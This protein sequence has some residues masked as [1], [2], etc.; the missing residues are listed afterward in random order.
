MAEIEVGH[1]YQEGKTLCKMVF[2]ASRKKGMD[3]TR[4]V[5]IRTH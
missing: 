4:C 2:F 1:I 5:G 3:L